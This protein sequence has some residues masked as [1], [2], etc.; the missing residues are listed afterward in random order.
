MRTLSAIVHKETRHHLVSFRYLVTTALTVVLAVLATLAGTA[1]FAQRREGYRD[2]L[3]QNRQALEEVPVYSYLQPVV[4]RP[5]E[6]LGI[7]DR[8]PAGRLGDEV[9]INVFT[10]PAAAIGEDRGNPYLASFQGFDLTTLVRVVLGLQALLLTFD[11]FVGERDRRTLEL[12]LAHGVSRRTVVAGKY[13]GALW[14]SLAALAASAAGGLAVIV[15]WGGIDLDA[16][17]RLRL[18]VAFAAYGAYLSLM[19]LVGLALSLA[20][21]R[22][23]QSLAYAI[24]AWLVLVFLLPSV[25]VA[26]AAEL[27]GAGG[28]VR[29]T[30]ARLE[31]ERDRRLDEA[32]AADPLRTGRNAH[33]A[34]FVY[35]TLP[36]AE[37]RRYGS[38]RYYDSLSAYHQLEAVVGMRYAERIF[39]ERRRAGREQHAAG[40]AAELLASL[41]PAFLL[42]RL[43]ESLAAT[44]AADHD[45]FLAACREYR[46]DFIA[47]LESRQAFRSWR[48]FTD[49]P[50]ETRPWT[51]F[52]GFR[53]EDVDAAAVGDLAGRFR[54]PEIQDRLR[55]ELATDPPL[56]LDLEGLPAFRWEAPDLAE[57]TRRVGFEVALFLTFHALLGACVLTRFRA[58]GLRGGE[59]RSHAR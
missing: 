27:R 49:D 2:R 33:S 24:L 52:L 6:P 31:R 53:P 57:A 42:E 58:Y 15:L 17:A 51:T 59:L 26:V 38:G 19:V 37:L 43:T 11:A 40:R 13:L 5:P 7:V 9:V 1:D 29:Q 54:S 14:A 20:A 55:D 22:A 18:G 50:P 44:S 21:R 36:R 35:S 39:E 25:A 41:S 23:S 10:V 3:E 56:R 12:T 48:W 28:E 34:P 30:V 45:E 46:R 4:V 16:Q 8:G 32:L 47:F